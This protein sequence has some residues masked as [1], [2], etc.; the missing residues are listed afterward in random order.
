MSPMYKLE[1]KPKCNIPSKGGWMA[2]RES[3]FYNPI[4]TGWQIGNCNGDLAT[5]HVGV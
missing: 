2:V 5:R 3:N 4:K 1:K